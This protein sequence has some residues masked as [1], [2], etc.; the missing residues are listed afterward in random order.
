MPKK[1]K[2]NK[3]LPDNACP[4]CGQAAYAVYPDDYPTVKELNAR[5]AHVVL[6]ASIG[7]KAQA[8]RVLGVAFRTLVKK[9]GEA[10]PKALRI[11]THDDREKLLGSIENST[12]LI[13]IGEPGRVNG[14]YSLLAQD[15]RLRVYDIRFND[16]V[17]AMSEKEFMKEGARPKIRFAESQESLRE[18]EFGEPCNVDSIAAIVKVRPLLCMAIV[19]RSK[20]NE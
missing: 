1:N 5:Y 11:M 12:P 14:T 10:T 4:L 6:K 9:I 20:S 2:A 19:M 3:D 16:A 18:F 17:L 7:N 15:K 13:P 8:S